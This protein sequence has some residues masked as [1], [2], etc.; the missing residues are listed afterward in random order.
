MVSLVIG[1]LRKDTV[2]LRAEP[3]VLSHTIDEVLSFSTDLSSLTAT[4]AAERQ[5]LLSMLEEESLL[6]S[7]LSVEEMCTF[8]FLSWTEWKALA[9][10]VLKM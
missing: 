5:S 8:A 7:W 6:A 9:L 10:G 2:Q 1:K 3:A 4:T